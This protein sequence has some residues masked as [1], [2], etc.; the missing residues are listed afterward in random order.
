MENLIC[1]ICPFI[2]S[3]V[4][5][6]GKLGSGVCCVRIRFHTVG[7]SSRICSLGPGAFWCWGPCL[8]AYGS[9]IQ[10]QPKKDDTVDYFDIVLIQ[11]LR[12]FTTIAHFSAVDWAQTKI[13]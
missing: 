7:C 12:A 9:N 1:S 11:T 5:V 13:F 3:F 10:Q 8:N 6:C 4:F 2:K